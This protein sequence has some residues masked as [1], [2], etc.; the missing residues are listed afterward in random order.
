MNENPPVKAN[1]YTITYDN[2]TTNTQVDTGK[3]YFHCS[4]GA[5]MSIKFIFG[6]DEQPAVALGF[7]VNSTN[8]FLTSDG[9]NYDLVSENV[10]ILQL[11]NMLFLA[12]DC[13][14]DEKNGILCP[15]VSSTVSTFDYIHF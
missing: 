15:I 13:V 4:T 11:E 1:V 6:S 10:I 8:T 5:P 2:Q 12:T 3:F 9:M 14:T 7:N